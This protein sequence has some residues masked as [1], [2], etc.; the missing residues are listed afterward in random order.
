[1]VVVTPFLNPVLLA[2]LDRQASLEMFGR[3]GCGRAERC[4][5]LRSNAG[6]LRTREAR[7]KLLGSSGAGDTSKPTEGCQIANSSVTIK[8]ATS[9][10]YTEENP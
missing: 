6:G 7:L 5:D 3:F 2:G 8:L 10:S 4:G 1:M 9:R